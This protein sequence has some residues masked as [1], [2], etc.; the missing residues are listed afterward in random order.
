M[1]RA[2]GEAGP[3]SREVTGAMDAVRFAPCK[4]AA[5]SAAEAAVAEEAAGAS[6]QHL[7]PRL[8]HAEW[9]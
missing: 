4:S 8:H 6:M 5:D 1:L 3:Q 2:G 9:A 7:A